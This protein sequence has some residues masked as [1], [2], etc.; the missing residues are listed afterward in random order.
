MYTILVVSDTAAV[1]SSTKLTATAV[2]QRL[3]REKGVIGLYKGCLATL[4][5]DVSFSAIYFPLFAHINALVSGP[6]VV[7]ST[8]TLKG[9]YLHAVHR[10]PFYGI[11]CG[12]C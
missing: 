5:R 12:C 3:L 10:I 11:G 4:L 2:A 1:N 9:A 8:E 6:I 7:S